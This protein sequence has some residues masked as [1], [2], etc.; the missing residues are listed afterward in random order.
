[1]LCLLLFGTRTHAHT[2]IHIHICINVFNIFCLV[3]MLV[4]LKFSEEISISCEVKR[5][6]IHEH[7]FI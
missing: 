4:V 5:H 2:Y 3:V 6:L 7:I 1:M